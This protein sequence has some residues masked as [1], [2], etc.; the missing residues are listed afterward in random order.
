MRRKPK[1]YFPSLADQMR[2]VNRLIRRT[3]SASWMSDTKWRKLF[4]ALGEADCGVERCVMKFVDVETPRTMN[5]PKEGDLWPPRPWIDSEFGP[6]ELRAI[7]WLDIPLDGVSPASKDR[8][9]TR[10]DI[11]K[12]KSVIEKLG[13]FPL[14]EMPD[15]IRI[16]GHSI[17]P[18]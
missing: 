15:R 14:I 3:A 1:H 17:P 10:I 11:F 9:A 12:A 5:F 6:L 4:V 7:E 8:P 13:Q 2:A 16:L 18:P